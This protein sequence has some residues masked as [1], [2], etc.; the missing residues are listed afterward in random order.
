MEYFKTFE[1]ALTHTF[2]EKGMKDDNGNPIKA[3]EQPMT[4][5]EYIEHKKE[6]IKG[7]IEKFNTQ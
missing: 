6:V 3:T 1:G 7:K 2:E 5:A 4:E